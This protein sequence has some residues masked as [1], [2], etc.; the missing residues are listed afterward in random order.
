MSRRPS[1]STVRNSFPFSDYT[2]DIKSEDLKEDEGMDNYFKGNLKEEKK[3][4][5][6]EKKAKK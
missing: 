6:K 3:Q 4:N 1:E 2:K 5:L